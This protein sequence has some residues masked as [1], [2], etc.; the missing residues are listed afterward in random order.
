LKGH[1]SV[2]MSKI[3]KLKNGNNIDKL[4][5]KSL[6]SINLDYRHGTGHG[7]GFFMNVHEGPQ[8]ISKNN[9]IKLKKGM[10]VSNEPGIY[11]E[12]KLGIRIENLVYIDGN[13]K[14]LFFRN[15]TFAPLEKDLINEN[16]LTKIEKDYIFSYHLETYSKLSVYLNNK[17]RKWLAKLIQ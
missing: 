11:L 8:S 13:N 7:V 17:E 4:A 9:F 3:D 10:I 16:M 1:I 15:L 2:A 6:N 12:N 5:R 14:N